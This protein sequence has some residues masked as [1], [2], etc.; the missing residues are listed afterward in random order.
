MSAYLIPRHEHGRPGKGLLFFETPWKRN[1]M[2]KHSFSGR[3]GMASRTH[4]TKK[5]VWPP[6]PAA[7]LREPGA[8]PTAFRDQLDCDPHRHPAGWHVGHGPSERQRNGP[9]LRR[10]QHQPRHGH[11]DR[12]AADEQERGIHYRR[13]WNGD[14]PVVRQPD[15]RHRQPDRNPCQTA[16]F[17]TATIST[18][19]R[20]REV[21]VSTLSR[22][23]TTR[24][25][26]SVALPPIRCLAEHLRR[27]PTSSSR[28]L[29]IRPLA[30]LRWPSLAE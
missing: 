22:A 5:P 28:P 15:S 20:P 1:I 29:T 30:T 23:A 19:P 7:G 4:R 24:P 11:A 21:Q 8:P 13:L 16:D 6:C 14:L 26:Q 27:L 3:I 9:H 12:H 25:K 17:I 18:E 10:D 2:S